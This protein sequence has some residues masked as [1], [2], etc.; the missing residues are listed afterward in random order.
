MAIFVTTPT[1]HKDKGTR[2][3]YKTC[4]IIPDTLNEMDPLLRNE[5]IV[6]IKMLMWHSAIAFEIHKVDFLKMIEVGAI[7]I[8][9]NKRLKPAKA[10]H[11]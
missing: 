6:P 1:F 7:T 3:L 5:Y 10:N 9:S 2:R 4:L 11:G 8:N